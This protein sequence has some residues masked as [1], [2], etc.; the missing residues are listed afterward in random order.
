VQSVSRVK[1]FW[2]VRD[3]GTKRIDFGNFCDQRC[4][5]RISRI[6]ELFNMR[7]GG[8]FQKTPIQPV[9]VDDHSSDHQLAQPQ[10]KNKRNLL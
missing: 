3:A 9:I 1:V 7:T 10:P 2:A 8:I 6:A 4:F 5:L